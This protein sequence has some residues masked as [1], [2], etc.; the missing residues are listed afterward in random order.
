MLSPKP[1]RQTRLRAVV[2]TDNPYFLLD[3]TLISCR[4]EAAVHFVAA[5]IEANGSRVSFL[6]WL[7]SHPEFEGEKSERVLSCAAKKRSPN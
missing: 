4:K 2:D 5:P 6:E 1:D 7:G 3:E